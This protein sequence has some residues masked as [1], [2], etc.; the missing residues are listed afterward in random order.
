MDNNRLTADYFEQPIND[1]VELA[2]E[3]IQAPQSRHGALFD[4]SG[5]IPVGLDQLDIAAGAGGGD[6][7]KNA[8]TL[9]H[10]ITIKN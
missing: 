4:A 3:L 5:V 8:A 6:L 9:S 1:T 10:T 7:D 2:G